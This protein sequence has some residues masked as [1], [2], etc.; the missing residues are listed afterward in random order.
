[1]PDTEGI[2][3]QIGFKVPR[4]D[5]WDNERDPI[6]RQIKRQWIVNIEN[7]WPLLGTI[8]MSW[9]M[10]IHDK[11]WDLQ[12]PGLVSSRSKGQKSEI[13]TPHRPSNDGIY[14]YINIP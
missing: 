6:C 11:S 14:I 9:N 8:T 13:S 1:M 7:V 12:K 10:N 5:R 3:R 4:R 2:E